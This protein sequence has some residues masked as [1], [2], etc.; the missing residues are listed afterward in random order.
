M[1]LENYFN[2]T[3]VVAEAAVIGLLLYRRVGR[4]LPL[5]VV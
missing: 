3:G 5:F 1:F 2:V 4:R